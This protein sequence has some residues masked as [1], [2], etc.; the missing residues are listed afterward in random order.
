MLG[1]VGRLGRLLSTAALLGRLLLELRL[2]TSCAGPLSPALL[3]WRLGGAATVVAVATEV[4]A[5]V[6]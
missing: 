3:S 1:G 5:A 6:I 2:P 4:D